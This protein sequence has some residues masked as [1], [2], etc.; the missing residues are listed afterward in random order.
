[1]WLIVS[2]TMFVVAG[3]HRYRGQRSSFKQKQKVANTTCL[4]AKEGRSWEQGYLYMPLDKLRPSLHNKTQLEVAV[5][6][7]AHTSDKTL[8]LFLCHPRLEPF[9][10]VFNKEFY[11]AHPLIECAR[12]FSFS[13]S[14]CSSALPPCIVSDED[15]SRY[16]F[17][18]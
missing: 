8:T 13:R 3:I 14:P 12:V 5:R 7:V 18:V 9:N 1:M 4:T 10:V 2:C 6:C 17:A 16:Y 11:R 15:P